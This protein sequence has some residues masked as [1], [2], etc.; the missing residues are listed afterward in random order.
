[1]NKIQESNPCGRAE[2]LVNYLYGESDA[3][4]SAGFEQHLSVCAACRDELQAFGQVREAV[5]AWRAELWQGAPA[6]ATADVL[7]AAAPRRGLVG[8]GSARS[9]WAA[10]REFFALSPAWLRFGAVAA[11]L[12]VCALA[13]LAV[14]NAEVGRDN[15]RLVFR[16]GVWHKASPNATQSVNS[17][18]VDAAQLNQLVAERDAAVRQLEEARAQLED[19]RAA[20]IQAVYD[21]IDDSS[22]ADASPQSQSKDA[23]ASRAR[24]TGGARKSARRGARSEEDLPRLLDLLGSGN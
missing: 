5:G 23:G 21:V 13:A 10:W 18:R 16:T 19:S 6:F 15:G 9:A 22:Q 8:A 2:Q 12:V 3:E 11:A 7:P 1:M 4:E 14:V 24:H 17:H 20:N